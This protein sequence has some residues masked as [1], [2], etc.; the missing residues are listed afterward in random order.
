[1]FVVTVLV[2]WEIEEHM[3]Q[4]N[5][6]IDPFD[7]RQL[8]SGSY[9]IRLGEYYYTEQQNGNLQ[10]VNPWCKESLE[11]MW[12]PVAKARP[13]HEIYD[14][15][16]RSKLNLRADDQIIILNPHETILAHTVE[17]IGGRNCV[18]SSMHAR[19]SIGRVTI[20]ICKCAGWGDHGYI[21]RWTMEI[22]NNSQSKRMMLL[23]GMRV[24]QIVFEETEVPQQDYSASGKYQTSSDL[25]EIKSKWQPSDMLPKL[26]LDWE[27]SEREE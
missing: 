26:W 20:E 17:F 22:T 16:E 27:L 15:H 7:Q 19:S 21:N 9:D 4:G 18:I 6:V 14:R 25:T 12:G 24:G 5:I 3:R 13:A 2:D 23:V 10:V 8:K 1:V 11:S